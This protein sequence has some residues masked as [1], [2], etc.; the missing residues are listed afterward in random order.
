MI[1]T[2]GDWITQVR[3]LNFELK[4]N[5]FSI[6]I[7][8]FIKKDCWFKFVL[9]FMSEIIITPC[10]KRMLWLPWSF[11]KNR[12][13]GRSPKGGRRPSWTGTMMKT[14][15]QL[16][17]RKEAAIGVK[18]FS[19]RGM[20]VSD[21]LKISKGGLRIFLEESEVSKIPMTTLFTKKWDLNTHMEM[22]ESLLYDFYYKYW[23]Y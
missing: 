9:L 2:Q 7:H 10:K 11:T 21:P 8:H 14:W 19:L 18:Q 13:A 6:L 16:V 12:R 23:F 5:S 1:N 17:P 4:V 15:W 20:V 3:C 22:G